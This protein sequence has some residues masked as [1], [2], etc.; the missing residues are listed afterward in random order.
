LPPLLN[1]R[2][3]ITLWYTMG[4]VNRWDNDACDQNQPPRSPRHLIAVTTFGVNDPALRTGYS[5]APRVAIVLPPCESS[6]TLSRGRRS[7][8][9]QPHDTREDIHPCC[10]PNIPLKA[11]SFGIREGHRLTRVLVHL[12]TLLQAL[13]F[14]PCPCFERLDSAYPASFSPRSSYEYDHKNTMTVRVN[15][16]GGR[17]FV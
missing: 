5:H 10:A 6:F 17:R 14:G 16:H 3:R 7:A 15:Q 2:R 13:W 12:R 8:P 11:T 4:K 1:R 9:W